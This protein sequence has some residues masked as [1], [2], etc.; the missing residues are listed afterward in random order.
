[1][2]DSSIK[3]SLIEQIDKLSPDHQRRLLDYAKR[4]EPKGIEGKTLLKFQGTIPADDLKVMLKA[5]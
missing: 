5:I 1:M 4:L 2:M 3:D